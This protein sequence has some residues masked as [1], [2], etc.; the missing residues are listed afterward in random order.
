MDSLLRWWQ[1]DPWTRLG[2]AVAVA[3]VVSVVLRALAYAVLRHLA[4]RRPLAADLLGRASAPMEWLIPL[5]ILVA[6]LRV[7]PDA[8]VLPPFV[9]VQ[10]VLL[11]AL[12]VAL[13]WLALRC[14]GT[15]E[16]AAIRKYPLDVA[17]NLAARRMIT[18][19]RVLRRTA[20]VLVLLLGASAILLTIPGVRQLGT[21][22][23]ASA[24]VAGL[25]LGIAAKPVLSNLIAGLQIAV[26]QPIRL[27]DVVII[28]GEWGRI[29]EITGSY[30]V[31]RIWDE[32]RMV[33]PLSWF[34]ENPFQNWTRTSA[35]LLG[36][37][38]LWMDYGV[39]TQP[40]REELG[41][42]CREA[43]EWDGR[44]CVLQVT[45]AN[46]RAVQLRALVSST[47]S[48]RNFDLRCK[49]REGLITFIKAHYPEALPRLRAELEG[50]GQAAPARDHADSLGDGA[51]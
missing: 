28:Q 27:D 1:H 42:L 20:D 22:L 21:S 32:R 38:F 36:T 48:G 14:L 33:V 30:V 45:D 39:P 29:E 44:V 50:S 9:L 46:E 7:L 35:Q 16:L 2:M 6:S 11:I 51:R 43:A 49:V 41:R 3:L 12:M 26:T 24:G 5:L 40:L 18:Q 47:D 34:M 4:K 8:D 10:H 17:D 25:A 37:V 15:L 23:L 31:V 13:T 19:V